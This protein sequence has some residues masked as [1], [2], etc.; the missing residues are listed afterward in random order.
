MDTDISDEELAKQM[1]VEVQI[2]KHLATKWQWNQART[3]TCYVHVTLKRGRIR[4]KCIR[5]F[6]SK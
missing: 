3:E 6:C 2:I 4:K 1:S 5:I